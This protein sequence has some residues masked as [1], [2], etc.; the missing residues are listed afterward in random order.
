MQVIDDP[1]GRG[2]ED[3]VL[4][5]DEVPGA[6]VDI[7]S[8]AGGVKGVRGLGDES[9]DDTGECVSAAAPRHS[10]VPGGIYGNSAVGSGDHGISAF[11]HHAYAVF[12][13]YNSILSPLFF[14]DYYNG[15]RIIFFDIIFDCVSVRAFDITILI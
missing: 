2:G 14:Y 10:R 11:E 15:K 7:S 12:L 1:R 6:A 5:R 4:P 3:A 9:G 13:Q 8:G